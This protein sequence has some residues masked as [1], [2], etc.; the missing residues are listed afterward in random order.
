MAEDNSFRESVKVSFQKA[1]KHADKLEND[2]NDLKLLIETQKAQINDLKGFLTTNNLDVSIG[3]QGVQA[4]N[5]SINQSIKHQAITK[6]SLSNQSNTKNIPDLQVFE[7]KGIPA[8]LSKPFKILTKQEFMAFLTIYQLEDE[9]GFATYR[10]IAKHMELS[11]S[12]IRGYISSSIRKGIQILKQKPNN[13][14]VILRIQPSFRELELKQRLINIF[15][16][17]DPEQLT[18]NR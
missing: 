13:H 14:S 1:K 9:K 11:P 17:K 6:Q 15:Y 10:D 18:L 4:I 16:R 2:L 5:Q 8:H 12:C 7:I 3:N